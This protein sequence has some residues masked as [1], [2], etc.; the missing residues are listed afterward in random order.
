MKG[1]ANLDGVFGCVE[2][3]WPDLEKDPS[4]GKVPWVFDKPFPD[5]RRLD[6][7]SRFVCL[8]VE[9]IGEDFPT[10]TA[11]VLATSAGCLHADR[12]FAASL[13]TIPSAGVFPYTLPSTCLGDVAIRHK[14]MGPVLCLT[15]PLRKEAL[16]EAQLLLD[17][18][19][20][21]AAI[22]CTGDVVPPTLVQ[23]QAELLT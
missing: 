17:M 21:D 9:A 10:R 2:V 20:A 14:I 11:L 16:A 5:F 15:T 12:K 23:I 13:E 8:A 7:L 4:S 18:D 22:V 6:P 1:V 19:E 3:R